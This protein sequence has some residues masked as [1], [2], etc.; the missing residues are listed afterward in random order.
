VATEGTDQYRV[1][2]T[3]ELV[4]PAESHDQVQERVCPQSKMMM[5]KSNRGD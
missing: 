4:A 3:P 1:L 2:V 5:R